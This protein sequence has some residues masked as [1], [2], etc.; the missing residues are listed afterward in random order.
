MAR[1]RE[2]PAAQN[3]SR[4]RG[5]EGANVLRFPG[6][7]PLRVA[8][9]DSTSVAENPDNFRGE[10]F[11]GPHFRELNVPSDALQGDTVRVTGIVHLDNVGVVISNREV[12]VR[13][14]GPSLNEPRIES[15]G[16][17]S[18]CQTRSFQVE[19]PTPNTP[20]EQLAL[21]VKSQSR[22]PPGGWYTGENA[23]PFRVNINTQ[24]QQR[25]A[26]ARQFAPF[27]VGGAGV[28]GALASLTDESVGTLALAGGAVGAGSKVVLDQ[29][30]GV[31]FPSFPT[32]DVAVAGGAALAI[33]LLLNTT[34]ASDVLGPAGEIAGSALDRG[35]K[36]V[37]SARSSN[38]DVAGRLPSA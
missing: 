29:T 16:K 26:T 36:A 25:R 3:G 14:D 32:Q 37:E 10:V 19:V 15:V 7:E 35:R 33:A 5:G 8:G 23:G 12:R 24:Q 21:T 38:T 27:V 31:N 11:K 2:R 9:V 6:G 30:G 1:N 34:G 17:L 20:D 13:V 4:A 28:G 18:H 22:T